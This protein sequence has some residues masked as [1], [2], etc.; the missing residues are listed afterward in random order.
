MP[1]KYAEAVW[2]APPVLLWL[3]ALLRS[4]PEAVR[5]FLLEGDFAVVEEALSADGTPASLPFGSMEPA[6]I[7]LRR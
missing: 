7:F 5:F 6:C 1:I 4:V 2:Q 3:R